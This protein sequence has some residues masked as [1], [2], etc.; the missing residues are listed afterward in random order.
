ME[1]RVR[2]AVDGNDTAGQHA[3]SRAREE[4]D[5]LRD[6]ARL[7]ETS[8]RGKTTL[9]SGALTIRRVCLGVGRAGRDK[10]HRDA[11]RTE[12]A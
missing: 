3:G 12:L 5:H 7:R 8:E 1:L 4:R 10:V 6:L 9:D 11:L 2:P